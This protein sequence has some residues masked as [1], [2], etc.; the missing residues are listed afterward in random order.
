MYEITKAGARAIVA[1]LEPETALTEQ[2]PEPAVEVPL[3]VGRAQALVEPNPV[4][5]R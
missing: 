1:W 3:A 2:D 4:F 5:V